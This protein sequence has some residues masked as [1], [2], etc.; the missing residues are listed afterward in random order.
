MGFTLAA[1]PS[2][3]NLAPELL[4]WEMRSV[5]GRRALTLGSRGWDHR[6]ARPHRQWLPL[7]LQALGSRPPRVA[8]PGAKDPPVAAPDQRRGESVHRNASARA[9]AHGGT[10]TPPP[11]TASPTTPALPSPNGTIFGGDLRRRDHLAVLAFKTGVA[12]RADLW[13]G[14][15]AL[16][17]YLGIG[18]SD[19]TRRFPFNN[20][21]EGRVA[22]PRVRVRSD[23]CTRA[24]AAEDRHRGA[25]GGE[26]QAQGGSG[27]VLP[28]TRTPPPPSARPLCN[29]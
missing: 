27:S 9:P 8:N 25:S 20:T 17:R 13:L 4:G 19:G 6:Q 29:F 14:D 15:K 10:A 5:C 26:A 1:G 3:L 24:E 11:G 16:R 22:V 7:Q 21:P 2:S 12:V 18:H 23:A 28:R